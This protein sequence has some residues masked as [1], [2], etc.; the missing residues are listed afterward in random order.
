MLK[1]KLC[2]ISLQIISF[3]D[4]VIFLL[5]LLNYDV[6]QFDRRTLV[7]NVKL[8]LF[9]LETPNPWASDPSRG[10]GGASAKSENSH[11]VVF[12]FNFVSVFIPKKINQSW[13]ILI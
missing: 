10:G 11:I 2:L 3:V 4:Q 13:N 12:C 1:N 5:F 7:L 8:P 9:C 6:L